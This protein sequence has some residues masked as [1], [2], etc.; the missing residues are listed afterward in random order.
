VL[1]SEPCEALVMP[2]TFPKATAN[3]PSRLEPSMPVNRL[4][5]MLV[6]WQPT[7]YVLSKR[8]YRLLL[9]GSLAP[10]YDAGNLGRLL[11]LSVQARDPCTDTTN[12]PDIFQEFGVN[13][14]TVTLCPGTFATGFGGFCRPFFLAIVQLPH[15]LLQP[16]IKVLSLTIGSSHP[17]AMSWSLQILSPSSGQKSSGKVVHSYEP[18]SHCLRPL[19]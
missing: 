3:V 12:A 5:T 2:N 8:F 4:I 19:K 11:R 13:F 16:N 14:I 15:F 9:R 1:L 18:S 17:N 6:A 10:G 7:K